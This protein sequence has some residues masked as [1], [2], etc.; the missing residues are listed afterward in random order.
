MNLDF[1]SINFIP[2]LGDG[3]PVDVRFDPDVSL[4]GT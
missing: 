1:E 3:C 2:Q 4:L